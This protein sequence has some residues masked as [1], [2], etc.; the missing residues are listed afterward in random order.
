MICVR[1]LFLSFL[2]VLILIGLSTFL[3]LGHAE[4][5]PD[6][7]WT[8]RYTGASNV[9]CCSIGVDCKIGQIRIVKIDGDMAIVEIDGNEV[10]L[11]QASVHQSETMQSYY[12]VRFG[13]KPTTESVRCIFWAIG[14]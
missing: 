4:H 13:E 11:P 5:T 8:H 10:T 12:C 2:V 3:T 6:T 1:K 7:F 14:T 9:P